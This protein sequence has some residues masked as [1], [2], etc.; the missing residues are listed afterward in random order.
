MKKSGDILSF[1]RKLMVY[2]LFFLISFP[3]WS[4]DSQ[5]MK[6]PLRIP[7]ITAKIKIDGNLGDRAWESALKLEL[8]YEVE[9]GENIKPPVRTE[10][11]LASSS[12]YLYVAFRAHDPDPE[13][14]I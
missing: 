13:R 1:L 6:V 5:A 12:H 9:P 10:V 2:H 11:F 7:E 8:Q 4:N 3:L 14:H